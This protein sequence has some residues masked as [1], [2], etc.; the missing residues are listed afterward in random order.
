MHFR[1]I[2]PFHS[3]GYHRSP[4]EIVAEQL[5]NDIYVDN[6]ITTTKDVGEAIKLYTD[7]KAMLRNAATNLREWSTN[8]KSV[9]KVKPNV[10]KAKL[11]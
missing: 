2:Q 9:N 4:S 1:V 8:S 11:R 10:D 7:S 5:K 6:V 3:W